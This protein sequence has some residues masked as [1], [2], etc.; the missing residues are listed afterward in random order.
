MGYYSSI[1]NFEQFPIELVPSAS[2]EILRR[3]IAETNSDALGE[4]DFWFSMELEDSSLVLSV[5]GAEG[6]SSELELAL[7]VLVTVVNELQSPSDSSGLQGLRF[8]FELWGEEPGDAVLY[9]SEG[10]ELLAIV[11]EMKFSGAPRKV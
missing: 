10:D 9:R 6:N 2:L 1:Y 11:G 8:H 3:R 4:L 5:D 7:K